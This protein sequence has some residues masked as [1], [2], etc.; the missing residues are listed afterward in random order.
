MDGDILCYTV[1]CNF[2]RLQVSETALETRGEERTQI[3]ANTREALYT[4]FTFPRAEPA[5]LPKVYPLFP[6]QRARPR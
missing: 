6:E 5:F 3:N 1:A 2:M 4:A